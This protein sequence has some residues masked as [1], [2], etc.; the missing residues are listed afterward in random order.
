MS[1]ISHKACVAPRSTRL[2]EQASD[3]QARQLAEK[4]NAVDQLAGLDSRSGEGQDQVR[5][6]LV[7][8]LKR[9]TSNFAHD[10]RG[11]VANELRRHIPMSRDPQR[12]AAFKVL[13]QTQTPAVLIELGYMSNAKDQKLLHSNEWQLQVG[14]AI[15]ASVEAFF[16]KR[17][18]TASR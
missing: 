16:A 2:S 18:A 1:P 14:T 15:A 5:N 11:L 8:L 6:I 7:D 13:K 17:P 3:E 9:E 4:E 10:F 12:S